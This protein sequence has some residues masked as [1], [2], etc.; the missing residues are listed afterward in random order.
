MPPPPTAPVRRLLFGILAVNG[1]LALATANAEPTAIDPKNPPQGVL[2]D[3]WFAVMMGDTKTG[4]M[5]STLRREGDDILASLDMSISLRRGETSVGIAIEQSYRET[6][7]GLPLEIKNVLS[8]A[9]QPIKQSGRIQDGQVHFVSEQ[10]GVKTERTY[11]FDPEVK[12][13]WGQYLEQLRHGLKPDVAYSLKAYDPMVSPSSSFRNEIKIIGPE[14]VTLWNQPQRAIKVRTT[15]HLAAPVVSDLWVD[16]AGFPLIM[17]MNL[18][19]ATFRILRADREA[20]LREEIAPEVFLSTFVTARGTVDRSA[21]R[22]TY[23]LSITKGEL[24]E[25]P[26][27]GM[28]SV[29]RIDAQTA[30]L[31]VTRQDWTT[32]S[33]SPSPP[34]QPIMNDF[35]RAS[36][37]ADA[38]DPLIVD[39]ARQATRSA[40]TQAE[41]ADALRVF[42]SEYVTSKSLDI[43][44]AT[45]SEV[46][47]TR[48]GD[49][50]EHSVLL[51]AMARSAGLPS[52]GVAGLVMMTK[53]ERS[54][55]RFGYHMWTQVY[56]GDQ[57][58]DID[59]AFNQTECDPTHIALSIM[60][61]NDETLIEGSLALLQLVGRLQIE[62]IEPAGK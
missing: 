13:P 53:G 30:E 19:I 25:L 11:S 51:G 26:S 21:K 16:E 61:L 58:M 39:L 43:A 15:S 35:L 28:Q 24:P 42:V 52:R 17:E 34:P 20:A 31:T 12:F 3:H 22:I 50:T 48:Q 36:T 44:F 7:S 1:C 23:R 57:W 47:R 46:A 9:G 62:I 55:A 38:R 2:I 33:T 59:A 27:T 18:G 5:R 54:E 4:H 40:K 37:Y 6:L 49:C 10:F 32:L 60:S 56:I 45:A 8:M 14:T 29:R 41:K